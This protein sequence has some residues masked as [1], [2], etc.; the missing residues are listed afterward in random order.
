M[1][2][3]NPLKRRHVEELQLLTPHPSSSTQCA[4][5][6]PPKSH[7]RILPSLQ[8][9]RPNLDG[10]W[11]NIGRSSTANHLALSSKNRLISR[12]HAKLRYLA[13]ENAFEVKCSGF[14]GISLRISDQTLYIK[15]NTGILVQ[16][17]EACD[18]SLNIAG[19]IVEIV[20]PSAHHQD[21]RA[22]LAPSSP[23]F[24]F[25]HLDTMIVPECR[26]TM[27]DSLRHIEPL[28]PLPSSTGM[29]TPS[30]TPDSKRIRN[31]ERLGSSSQELSLADLPISQDIVSQSRTLQPRMLNFQMMDSTLQSL[32]KKSLGPDVR[33]KENIPPSPSNVRPGSVETSLGLLLPASNSPSPDHQELHADSESPANENLPTE[34]DVHTDISSINASEADEFSTEMST[35]VQQPRVESRPA[36]IPEDLD[37]EIDLSNLDQ[38]FI[39]MILTVLA[40]SVIHPAPITLLTPFFPPETKVEQIQDFLRTQSCI[41][42]LK[43]HNE[44]SD[45]QVV[46]STW[47]Y[48]ATMDSDVVRRS[49]LS[50]LQK[51]QRNLRKRTYQQLHTYEY[52]HAK[53]VMDCKAAGI[54]PVRFDGVRY[55]GTHSAVQQ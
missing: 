24:P 4:P 19:S 22:E 13:G 45:Q 50:S 32:A 11:Y 33:G 43:V 53:Y 48:D 16:I 28:S 14:N 10:D 6:S 30:V 52:E 23:T 9:A 27:F 31:D 51:P 29:V 12:V 8:Y 35:S 55:R 39:D 54:K 7:N 15:R 36:E 37:E 40:T 42:E 2:P 38:E 20:I 17:H 44:Y 18:L 26:E 1:A 34:Q 5:S 25:S 46:T 49:R 41:S 3:A 21:E 47:S